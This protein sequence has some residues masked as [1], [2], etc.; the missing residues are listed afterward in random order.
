MARKLLIVASYLFVAALV[1][2]A[3]MAMRGPND[4]KS[5]GNAS[6]FGH[7]VCT[8]VIVSDFG[9]HKLHLDKV[10]SD[11]DLARIY[12]ETELREK[13]WTDSHDCDSDDTDA[14]DVKT[15]R[16]KQWHQ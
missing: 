13:E 10:C 8:Q 11:A 4:F 15:I 16:W 9:E 2:V 6:L 5:L 12:G 7:G 1:A 3:V 14:D